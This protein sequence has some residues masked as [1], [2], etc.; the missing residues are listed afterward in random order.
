MALE[1]RDY[2]KEDV[3]RILDTPTLGIFNEQRTGKTPTAIVG[4]TQKCTRILIVCPNSMCYTWQTELKKWADIDAHVFTAKPKIKKDVPPVCI[5][6]YEKLPSTAGERTW[7]KILSCMDYEGLI[8]DEAHRIKNTQTATNRAIMALARDIPNRLAL[9]GTPAHDKPEDIFAILRFLNPALFR[10]KYK[11]VADWCTTTRVFTP[12]GM[13]AK[14]SGIKPERKQ[15]FINMLN[16]MAIMRKRTWGHNT[17]TIEVKLKLTKVQQ[18]YL[19]ELCD[20][21]ETKDEEQNRIITQGVLDRI[22]RYRQICNHPGT[23]NLAGDSPKLAWII[24]YIKD[25][26]ENSVLIFSNSRKFLEKL[27]YEL[28]LHRIYHRIIAGGT[29][30]IK[31]TEIQKDFQD[32]NCTVLLIQ[33]QAGKEG[34]TLDSADVTIFCDTYPPLADYLQ[35]KDRMAPA[36]PDD[37]RLRTIYRLMMEDSYD[38]ELYNLIDNNIEATSIINNFINYVRR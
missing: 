16:R 28:Q 31:R 9:T 35:A 8:I 21:F 13:I 11:F 32:K 2:Q 5:I 7:L 18:K 1:L 38:E 25:Y 34:L 10:S 20:Y 37:T 24:N 3:Q 29:P 30:P 15:E 26:P 6:N 17:E 22:V 19:K 23:A 27:S 12:N 4:M 36:N 33:T 14:P